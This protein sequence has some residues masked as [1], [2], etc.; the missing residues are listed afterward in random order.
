VLRTRRL[1]LVWVSTNPTPSHSATL[2]LSALSSR[3]HDQK[4]WLSDFWS[5]QSQS[6]GARF[7]SLLCPLSWFFRV[8][9]TFLR[10]GCNKHR[11]QYV[12]CNV[13]YTEYIQDLS[14][15]RLCTTYI[16]QFIRHKTATY[17]F[18]SPKIDRS[19]FNPVT[20]SCV[21]ALLL[22]VAKLFIIM[23]S[24]RLL[25]AAWINCVHIMYKYQIM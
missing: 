11:E 13:T 7:G 20:N 24:L 9:V 10:L 18:Y 2:K 6:P 25:L 14:K 4:L 22:N 19:K 15:S 12:I 17:S 5:L 1:T 3:P 8:Q 21:G 23:T 16:S